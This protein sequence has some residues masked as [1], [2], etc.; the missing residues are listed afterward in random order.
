MVDKRTMHEPSIR[1][2]LVI[3]GPGVPRGK[4]VRQQVLTTDV[5]PSILDACNAPP[6][7]KV[8]GR[9]WLK[10]VNE[11][12]A[13]WRTAWFYEYNYEKQFPYTP[14]VRGIRTDRWKFIRYPH[15]DKS[16]DKHLPELYDLTNDPDEL[17]NLAAA[18]EHAKT[19]DELATQLA[20]LLAAEGMTPERDRMPLDQGVKS[21]LPDQKIR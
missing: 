13:Q 1:I 3:C 14:N 10:L 15:G 2:P 17:H 18:E 9:S 19:R 16:P 4:I 21:E 6:L 20:R 7:A 11:G 5:A 12:D 8:Q